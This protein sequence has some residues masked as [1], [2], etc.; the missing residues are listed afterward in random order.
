MKVQCF[1]STMTE[2]E[3]AFILA[4]WH[5][6]AGWEGKVAL[7]EVAGPVDELRARVRPWALETIPQDGEYWAYLVQRDQHGHFNR[8]EPLHTECV[9]W[10]SGEE[11]VPRSMLTE[12]S[13]V[14]A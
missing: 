4:E 13:P 11:C 5:R 6:Y 3:Y 1:T 12:V 10:F 9:Y 8:F 7:E 2:P 14:H